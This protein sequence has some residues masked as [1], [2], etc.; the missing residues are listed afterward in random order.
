MGISA[1]IGKLRSSSSSTDHTMLVQIGDASCSITCRSKK[2]FSNLRSLF[3]NFLTDRPADVSIELE[4]VSRMSAADF[5]IALPAVKFIHNGNCFQ[6]ESMIVTGEHDA[7]AT[8]ISVQ[9]EKRLLGTEAGRGLV[10][11]A[12]ALL[13]Y[14]A[15]KTKHNGNPPAFIIHSSSIIH[16]GR[17]LLFAGPSESGKTTIGWLCSKYGDVLN[18]EAVLLSHPDQDSGVIRV[19]GL[20]I[21]GELPQRLN[22]TAPLGCVLLIKQ[23]D[24]TALRRL[25]RV[26]AYLRFMRQIISPAY[27]GQDD[28]RAVYS[29]ISEFSDEVTAAVPFYELEFTL[30]R[31]SLWHVLD[32]LE[33][34]LGRVGS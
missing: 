24:K 10:N 13:Y 16:R 17:V 31:Q 1:C 14:S 33:G 32:E 4:V 2:V 9:V 34:S 3:T 30:D 20:P 26:D 8:A 21:V 22:T 7:A 12:L 25:D 5:E 19:Q 29:L 15:C 23:S 11:R 28:R 27:M 18:D 6:E